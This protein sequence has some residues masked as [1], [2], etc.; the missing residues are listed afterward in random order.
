MKRDWILTIL[1]FVLASALWFFLYVEPRKEHLYTLM[2]D[3][4]MHY[5]VQLINCERVMTYS[6]CSNYLRKFQ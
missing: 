5:Q 4:E 3:E 2:D 1:F 6:E